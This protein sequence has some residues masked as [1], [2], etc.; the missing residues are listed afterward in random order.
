MDII[1]EVRRGIIGCGDVCEIKSGPAF[2][3]V[4]NS[5]LVA[6]MRRDGEKAKDFALRNSVP[7][8]YDDAHKLI[9]D[10]DINAIYIATPP[11]SHE[12]Y[13]VESMEAGKPVYIEKPVTL[14]SQSCER[15]IQSSNKYGIKASVAHYRRGLSIFKKIRSLVNSGAIGK[16]S[17]IL[18]NTLQAPKD[19]VNSPDNWRVSPEVS[20]GGLFHDLSPHQL[21]IVYWIFGKPTQVYGHSL[22]QR[23]IYAAPDL[24]TLDAIFAEKICLHGLWAFNVNPAAEIETCEIIGDQGKITFSFFV[25]SDI[26]IETASGA[27]HLTFDYPVNIQQPMIDEVVKFFK[28]QGPNPCSLEDALVTMKMMDSSMR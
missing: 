8:F 18:V 10:P 28:G 20:G 19:T 23:S 2:N 17:L 12:I 6:V 21:D 26:A 4:A 1:N 15:M 24:T 11:D 25:K 7:K 16:V 14:N 13:T 5:Q 3:K 9:N 27:E 22:T